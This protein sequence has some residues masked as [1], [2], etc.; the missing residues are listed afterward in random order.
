[1]KNFI[2]KLL[3]VSWILLFSATGSSG[4][5]VRGSS[6]GEIYEH[7]FWYFGSKGQKWGIFRSGDNGTTISV[8]S[9]L[10]VGS[11]LYGDSLPGT[12]YLAYG[13]SIIRS[14][15][16]GVSWDTINTSFFHQF[17]SG[18]ISGEVYKHVEAPE[19]L[20][21]NDFGST[22]QVVDSTFGTDFLVDV[23]NAPGELYGL[24][25]VAG[26]DTLIILYSHDYGHSFTS[27]LIDTSIL[28]PE[29]FVLDPIFTRGT[30][31]GEFYLVRMDTT[32]RYR[33]F[34]TMDNGQTF[35][36]NYITQPCLQC[37]SGGMPLMF[38]FTA[39]REPGSFYIARAL[40]DTISQNHTILCIDYSQDYGKTYTT[41]CFDLDSTFTGIGEAEFP[42][43]NSLEQNYPNP[44][45]GQTLIGFYLLKPAYAE[46]TVSDI[47]G[48]PVATLLSGRFASGPHQ[49]SWDGRSGSGT[50][51]PGGVY[52]YRLTLDGIPAG[53][54]KAV[55]LAR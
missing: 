38:T 5:V 45:T 50:I 21:S 31:P 47:R 7:C 24:K 12:V 20:R 35:E 13:P 18:F 6:P 2:P 41:H 15:D 46:I 14:Q 29:C 3:L 17:A 36:Y 25:R 52:Y 48:N 19:L 49:V 43:M 55:L 27:I 32:A 40:V 33:V 34:H 9:V 37:V 42:E 1:M 53:V 8:Q 16:Y 26:W 28:N 30:S 10:G 51:L 44:F 22:F 4:Q 54:K 11:L 23:G 39:G